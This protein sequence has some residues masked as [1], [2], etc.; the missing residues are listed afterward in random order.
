MKHLVLTNANF[1]YWHLQF[2]EFIKTIGYGNGRDTNYESNIKEFL[3]FLE[4]KNIDSIQEVTQIHIGQYYQY[5][6][7]RPAGLDLQSKSF[8]K[9]ICNPL[10]TMPIMY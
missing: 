2:D 9:W 3:H 6:S 10:F 4:T 8:T 7:N 5:L 1:V